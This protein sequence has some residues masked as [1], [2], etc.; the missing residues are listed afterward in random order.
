MDKLGIEAKAS[1]M[2]GGIAEEKG[3]ELVDLQLI[4]S[5]KNLTLRVFID[6]K[7]G[8]SI[9]DCASVSRLLSEQLD[10]D[11]LI[12]AAY[13]LEVSSPGLDRPLK[14]IGDFEK[15]K[16]SPA[17]I[18]T[19]RPIEGQRNFSGTLKGVDGDKILIDDKTTGVLGIDHSDIAKANLEVDMQAELKRQR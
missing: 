14:S 3:L 17:K 4:G 2:V 11:D 18:R 6:K 9:D 15:F 8:V 7:G 5:A 13:V 16:G 19:H 1:A 12:P 10:A